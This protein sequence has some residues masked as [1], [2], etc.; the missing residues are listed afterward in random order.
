MLKRTGKSCGPAGTAGDGVLFRSDRLLVRWAA[1]P[2]G[3]GPCFVNFDA[4]VTEA[5]FDRPG[6]G[7]AFFAERGIDA[8]QVLPVGNHWYHYPDMADALAA[9]RRAVAGRDRVVAYGSSMGGYAALVHGRAAGA[10][11]A[12]A[13]SPQFSVDPRIVPF[14]DR[15]TREARGIRFRAVPHDP[16]AEAYIAYDSRDRRERRH[17]EM[18]AARAP[19]VGL[20]VAHG[21]HPVGGVLL[22][23]GLLQPLVTAVGQGVVTAAPVIAAVAA[24]R[25]GTAQYAYTLSHRVAPHRTALRVALAGLAVARWPDHAGFV[26]NLG[27]QLDRAGR[28]AEALPL[29]EEAIRRGGGL[30]ARLGLVLHHERQGAVRLALSL[31]RSL[32]ADYPRHGEARRVC[33]RLWWKRLRALA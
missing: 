26:G 23:A 21:G 28:P 19:V 18:F 8:I 27:R 11:A 22:E 31:A 15:W 24:A 2:S 20:P 4:Y 3:R 17:F 30:E 12:L 32:T 13:L 5:G 7:E 16:V 14:E 9:I 1:V 10:D 25:K 6:F 33:R 29:H